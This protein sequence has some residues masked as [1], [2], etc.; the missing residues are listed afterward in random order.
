MQFLS[1]SID[2][3]LL[4]GLMTINGGEIIDFDAIHP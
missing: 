1:E 3:E 2:A 4:R